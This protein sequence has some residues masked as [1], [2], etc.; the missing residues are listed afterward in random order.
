MARAKANRA[1]SKSRSMS[2]LKD[3]S[4]VTALE[5]AAKRWSD[6]ADSFDSASASAN[7][8]SVSLHDAA[9]E[10]RRLV[11]VASDSLIVLHSNRAAAAE[12]G[13]PLRGPI[14]AYAETSALQLLSSTRLLAQASF[15]A[16]KTAHLVSQ[17]FVL[18]Q[19]QP[20]A[21]LDWRDDSMPD[22]ALRMISSKI[23][24][25][26]SKVRSLRGSMVM[27]AVKG[28]SILLADD[29]RKET[30]M[31]FESLMPTAKVNRALHLPP[32]SPTTNNNYIPLTIRAAGRTALSQLSPH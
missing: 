8:R 9:E 1:D 22:D 24:Q 13:R 10:I 6:L 26:E 19:L 11:G 16:T 5:D 28:S 12:T 15:L 20:N 25:A 23:D 31:D 7:K 4:T 3:L 14:E 21:I 18:R 32:L 2:H 30:M 29:I 27:E 17:P